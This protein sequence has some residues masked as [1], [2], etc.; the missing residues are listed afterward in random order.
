ML[1]IYYKSQTQRQ[2]NIYTLHTSMAPILS[3][4]VLQLAH[5]KHYSSVSDLIV[6]ILPGDCGATHAPANARTSTSGTT[7]GHTVTYMCNSGY[8]LMG[9]STR[10]CQSNGQWSG[11]QPS[12]ARELAVHVTIRVS[13]ISRYHGKCGIS[14][15]VIGYIPR[16]GLAVKH[17][18]INH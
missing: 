13:C 1:H 11:S 7:V 15:W 5:Y 18:G 16:F 12:C 9:N 2:P 17:L 3:T 6:G 4:R 10:T 8:K 14:V